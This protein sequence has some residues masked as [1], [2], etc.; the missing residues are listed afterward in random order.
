MLQNIQGPD[1]AGGGVEPGD[2]DIA[3]AQHGAELVADELDDGLELGR[4]AQAA[5]HGVDQ[6]ELID[7]SLC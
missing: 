6:F 7:G 2:A 4:T 5:Q 1:Q 3:A